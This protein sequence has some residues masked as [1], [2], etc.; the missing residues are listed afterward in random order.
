[1]K[2]VIGTLILLIVLIPSFTGVS[3]W[4]AYQE[5]LSPQSENTSTAPKIDEVKFQ[6]INQ[7]TQ[8]RRHVVGNPAKASDYLRFQYGLTDPFKH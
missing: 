7:F 1:M 4:L 8:K 3:L 5:Y 6:K 2:I